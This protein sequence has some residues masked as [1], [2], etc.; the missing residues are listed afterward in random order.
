MSKYYFVKKQY[1]FCNG[2]KGKIADLFDL[3]GTDYGFRKTR[4]F[5]FG[6]LTNKWGK[7]RVESR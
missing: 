5:V 4:R 2:R 3:I 7:S 1:M 6:F